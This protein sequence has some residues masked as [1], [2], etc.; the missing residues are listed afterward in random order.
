[1]EMATDISDSS[2][3]TGANSAFIQDLYAK[4]LQDAGSVDGDWAQ[5]FTSLNDDAHA[6]L[7]EHYGASWAPKAKR[8]PVNGA[9]TDFAPWLEPTPV[10]AKGKKDGA[11]AVAA[12]I[13]APSASPEQIREATLDSIRALMLIRAYRVRGHLMADLDPLGL[14]PTPDHPELNP[15]TYGFTDADWDRPIFIN[16]VL[17]LE[18]ATLREILQI[19]RQTYCDKIG[20]EFMHIQDP[21][22]KAWIQERVESARGNPNL[23][24]EEKKAIYSQLAQA[25]GFEKYLQLKYTGTKRFGLDGSESMIPTLEEII[26]T[27]RLLGVEEIVLGMPHRG[28]LN[29]LTNIMGKSYRALFSEFQGNPANPEDVGGSG[30]VKYHLG[31]SGDREFEGRT[32]HLSLNPNPSHLEAVD[33][34]VVGKVRAKQ[35]Q[36]GDL[37][38]EKVIGILMHGDAAFAGQGLVAETFCFSG[39][40][41]YRSGGTVHVIVNNQIGFTTSPGYSRSSPYPSDVAKTVQAPIFHVNGDHPEAV[42]HVARLAAQYRHAFKKDVVIDLFCYRRHG[43]NEG[44]EPAFTQPL[45]YR[46]I[47][48]LPT[49]RQRYAERLVAEGVLSEAEVERVASDFV[50]NLETQFEAAKN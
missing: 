39:L 42:V 30:D 27:S 33:P 36:R 17:G 50:A 21:A 11:A 35:A 20:V 3:L 2:I 45:M 7:K 44:D 31:T 12:L 47:A 9:A 14:T 38:R 32:L 41:G 25:E 16:H 48:R 40:R 26:H 23:S 19:V 1:M 37:V 5:F 49:T 18:T 46:T 24:A 13:E 10:Q 4:W 15:A 22:E 8:A 6:V 28:R 34:V 29:V 43:H